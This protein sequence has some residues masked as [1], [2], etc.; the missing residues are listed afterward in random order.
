MSGCPPPVPAAPPP[1]PPPSTGR[2]SLPQHREFWLAHFRLPRAVRAWLTD[3]FRI[4]LLQRPPRSHLPNYVRPDHVP[5]VDAEV[6]RLLGTG[7]IAETPRAPHN[8]S[9]LTCAPKKSGKLRLCVD[10]RFVNLFVNAPPFKLE[11]LTTLAPMLR[12]GDCLAT[13]DLSEGYHHLLIHPDSRQHLGFQWGGRYFVFTVLPFGLSCAP[14]AFTKFVRPVVEYLRAQGVRLLSYIDDFLVASRS[15]RAAADVHLFAATM[16][17]AGFV[18]KREK[19]HLAPSCEQEFLGFTVRTSPAVVYAVPAD[20][21]RAIKHEIRRLLGAPGPVHVRRVAHVAGLCLSV[22][23][24]IMPAK[25]LLR[26]V[27][28][29]IAD[30]PS[31]N[32]RF[33]LSC[34]ARADLAWWLEGLEGWNGACPLPLPADVRCATDASELGWGATWAGGEASG[35][36]TDAL[37]QC[38]NNVRESMAV[39]NALRVFAPQWAGKTVLFEC[40]NATT[41]AHLNGFGRLNADLDALA[42][43]IHALAARHGIALRAAHI[44][45]VT[46]T[47]ADGLSRQCDR[48]DWMLHRRVFHEL[49]L[50]WGP[51]SIDRM[52]TF[53]TRQVPRYES[54]HRDVGSLRAD[55]FSALWSPTENSWVNPPFSLIHRVLRHVQASRAEVTLVAPVWPSQPWFPLLLSMCVDWPVQLPTADPRCFR[56]AATGHAEPMKNRCWRVCAWR[57]SGAP[58][59]TLGRPMLARFLQAAL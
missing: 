22:S 24:A 50:L 16:E 53:R 4:P 18:L 55:T 26:N 29:D 10:M 46:N 59:R 28:R 44:A 14:W 40:D 43:A 51:H 2:P 57:I 1:P 38:S 17:Q 20:K 49:D 31:W 47:A 11:D 52:A 41:V 15:E 7:A 25:L 12:A 27:Y 36:W 56:P 39:L 45:G 37:A 23:R 58:R 19:C 6:A 32:A 48:S 34:A 13:A 33:R 42:R 9:P 54:R 8:V 5:F 21:R 35:P 3:G 30:A